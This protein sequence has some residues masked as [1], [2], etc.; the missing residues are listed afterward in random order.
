MKAVLFCCL[1]L[2]LIACNKP[3]PNPELKD[4]IYADL[5]ARRKQI[6]GEIEAEKKNLEEAQAE[7]DK[8]VPQTGQVK[9]AQKHYYEIKNRIEKLQQ[10]A[11]YYK[12]RHESRMQEARESYLKAYKKGESWP[13][14][15]EFEDY[16]ISES[17]RTKSRNWSVKERMEKELP[18]GS[19]SKAKAGE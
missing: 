1:A 3:D 17:A 18:S 16:R 7:I 12:L 11:L 19:E 15:Q 14:P 8:A 4:P 9:F 6:E 2:I 10:Q 13:D 5:E